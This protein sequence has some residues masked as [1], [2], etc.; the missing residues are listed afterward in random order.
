VLRLVWLVLACSVVTTTAS[1]NSIDR[2]LL[3]DVLVRANPSVAACGLPRGRYVVRLEIDAGG[4][5]TEASL[6]ESPEISH[7]LEHCVLAAF[8]VLRFP[9]FGPPR[10]PPIVRPRDRVV[11]HLPP[12][13]ESTSIYVWWPLVVE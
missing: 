13:R 2:S 7:R 10:P 9:S 5:V 8:L 3:R 6:G 4:T 11:S 12:V 1:A